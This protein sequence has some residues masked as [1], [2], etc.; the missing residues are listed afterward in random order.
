MNFTLLPFCV[1]ASL[2]AGAA[3]AQSAAPAT[4]AAPT[5]TT[6]DDPKFAVFV[7]DV[8]SI[9][10]HKDEP[11][12]TPR[13]MGMREEPDGAT[14]R[15][16]PAV[17]LIGQAYKTAHYKITGGPDWAS[18]DMYDIEAKM[19]P[20][21]ADAFAKLS[22]PDQKLAR[23][24]MMQALVK[25]YLK[26]AIHMDTTEVP[27][28][29]LVIAKRGLK[30]KEVTDPGV[31]DGGYSLTSPRS[32]IKLEAHATHLETILPTWSYTA[33]RPV[34]DETGLTGRYSFTLTY[35]QNP[36]ETASSDVSDAAPPLANALEEQLGL[37]LVPAKG[38]MDVIVIDHVEK[39]PVD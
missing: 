26:V 29:D 33:G 19:D 18:K 25:D 17:F 24:H 13:W 11:L 14:M 4:Q 28:F 10:P 8:V 36:L 30:I 21:V 1:V 6:P 12:G 39:P 9:R 16:I 34:Y 7:F 32:G 20:E 31:P 2:I 35:V 5:V 15:S 27:V 23:Q 37:K 22:V 38:K 3:V